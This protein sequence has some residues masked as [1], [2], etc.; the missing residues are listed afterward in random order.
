MIQS[1]PLSDRVEGDQRSRF[2]DLPDSVEVTKNR[3]FGHQ[4]GGIV[5]TM[6]ESNTPPFVLKEIGI[7]EMEDQGFDAARSDVDGS[8]KGREVQNE[9]LSE[10]SGP[11]PSFEED[12][13]GGAQNRGR[14]ANNK[15]GRGGRGQ[16]RALEG[17]SWANVASALVKSEVSL[18]YYPLKV[19][20]D[21]IVVEMPPSSPLAKWEACLVGYF[22][23]KN[24][25]YTFVKNN[26]FNMWKNKGLV[27]ILKNDDGFIFFMFENRDCCIDVLEGGP[28]YVGGFLLILKQW[29]CM[30][31]LSK[32]DKKSIPIWVK[33]IMSHWNTGMGMA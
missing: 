9:P 33:F 22:I 25:P 19:E 24:L 16:Y 18:K 32:E 2:L 3:G 5:E 12:T 14:G 26:A 31:R 30:M 29:H 1:T 4:Q 6:K 7:T 8:P 23:D 20:Q 21:K 10:E 17:R 28:W 27:D 11:N 13:R 15:G